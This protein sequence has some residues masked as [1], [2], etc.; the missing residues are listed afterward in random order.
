MRFPDLIRHGIK[1]EVCGVIAHK[2]V[3]ELFCNS[4]SVQ[5]L[6]RHISL[7]HFLCYVADSVVG[8]FS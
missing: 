1:H 6:V 2:E 4:G 7:L 3:K 5:C 8:L